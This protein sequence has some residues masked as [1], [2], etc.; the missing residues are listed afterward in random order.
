MREGVDTDPLGAC[1]GRI[2]KYAAP[3]FPSRQNPEAQKTVK[4]QTK[5][6]P[7][8]GN[9]RINKSTG[10]RQSPSDWASKKTWQVL[11]ES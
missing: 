6:R 4:K 9:A 5:V 10:S 7:I 1:G 11:N 8:P 3:H 2:S